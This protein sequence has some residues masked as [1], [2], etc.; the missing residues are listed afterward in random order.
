MPRARPS[1]PPH[2]QTHAHA[3]S[4]RKTRFFEA[5]D[6]R[7]DAGQ[8]IQTVTTSLNIPYSTARR[9]LSERRQYGDI[10]YRRRELREIK[11]KEK[12]TRQGP[13]Y[14]VTDE[15]LDTLLSRDRSVNP[16]RNRRI[17]VQRIHHQIN[18]S[19]RCLQKSLRTR[20]R[21]G[22][23]KAAT[24]KPITNAQGLKRQ[25][26]GAEHQYE[27]IEGFW[28]GVFFCDE[29]HFDPGD[30]HHPTILREEGSRYSPENIAQKEAK[31]GNQLHFAAW[32]NW[33]T[34]A[35]KLIFYNDEYRDYCPPKKPP[36]PRFRPTRE[37]RDEYTR[38]V[39]EWEASLPREPE[40]QK[41]GNSMRAAYYVKKILPVYKEAFQHL[42]T[43]SNQ[44]RRHLPREQRYN[45]YIVEDSDPSHGNKNANSLP[46]I[47]RREHGMPLLGHPPNSC[48]LNAIEGVFNILKERVKERLYGCS[49]IQHVEDLLQEEWSRITQDE[50]Q[51]RIM[52][53]PWRCGEVAKDGTKRI[54]SVLW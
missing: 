21:A 53:M 50:I 16:V 35:E 46:S 43:Q 32:V 5:Y 1:T 4:I 33:Y 20:R 47:Y 8:N 25:V 3:D 51:A 15:Q 12:G 19:K 45:W 14:A 29:A 26:Y 11:Q 10:A 18:A 40:I 2:R 24:S 7:G 23:Y 44:L 22:I 9:W 37:T 41:P 34:K 28:D 49:T 17:D 13:T 36:K 39:A 6:R 54:K 31:Q 48:D 38:R 30:F 27:P 42:Q 52:E